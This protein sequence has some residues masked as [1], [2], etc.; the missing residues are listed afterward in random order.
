MADYERYPFLS[1]DV[2]NN[3]KYEDDN[4]MTLR[5]PKTNRIISKYGNSHRQLLK[6]CKLVNPLM[7]PKE[8]IKLPNF[9]ISAK[10]LNESDCQ[11]YADSISSTEDN[12]LFDDL[13]QINNKNNGNNEYLSYKM[14]IEYKYYVPKTDETEYKTDEIN[15]SL[16]D[17]LK[18][19]LCV[20]Y[21]S[22]YVF[23]LYSEDYERDFILNLRT[24][25]GINEKIALML[26]KRSINADNEYT[27]SVNEKNFFYTYRE[28]GRYVYKYT[29]RTSDIYYFIVLGFDK[30]P[31]AINHIC[32]G[33]AI[34]QDNK[35]VEFC[36]QYLQ[37]NNIEINVK[38]TNN[39]NNLMTESLHFLTQK[40][41]NTYMKN[42]RSANK[43][44]YKMYNPFEEK[45]ILYKN[46]E[47]YLPVLITLDKVYSD[48]TESNLDFKIGNE[49]SFSYFNK[50]EEMCDKMMTVSRSPRKS[51]SSKKS[52]SPRKSRSPMKSTKP[53]KLQ[54]I[55]TL[56]REPT[57]NVDGVAKP[58]R[59]YRKKNEDEKT[60]FKVTLDEYGDEEVYM[61][62]MNGETFYAYKNDKK[63]R[64]EEPRK[65]SSPVSNEQKRS[66][67]SSPVKKSFSPVQ[68]KQ[69]KSMEMNNPLAET[70]APF[71]TKK[72]PAKK[73]QKRRK[74]LGRNATTSRS[75]FY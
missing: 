19:Y 74:V 8:L 46:V 37:K 71:K 41:F 63:L 16:I 6:E 29:P 67:S 58:T 45:N 1:T 14:K 7:S 34:S 66:K 27:L 49:Y 54:R 42:R 50:K 12:E 3:I 56:V 11:K 48:V 43:D 57:E 5:S 31:F 59:I 24:L 36:R 26:E 68:N 40:C 35:D 15:V 32:N 10:D 22:I 28:F 17:L 51:R 53:K 25:L 47:D 30:N 13:I 65:S 62:D 4:E 9:P 33:F 55:L 69:I 21:K 75:G 2:C 60:K 52:R 73:A 61:I 23:N 18:F 44:N 39:I 38:R 20:I 64:K 72:I 70:N